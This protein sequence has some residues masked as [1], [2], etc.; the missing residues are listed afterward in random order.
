MKFGP[1]FFNISK[2]KKLRAQPFKAL[3]RW[4]RI[5][6]GGSFPESSLQFHEPAVV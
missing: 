2:F 6:A 3:H 5:T 4:L 1:S